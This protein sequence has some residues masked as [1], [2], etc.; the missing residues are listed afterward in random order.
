MSLTASR[1]SSALRR[2]SASDGP[3]FSTA[4]TCCPRPS[5][6][7]VSVPLPQNSSSTRSA[8]P[9]ARSAS[10]CSAGS[11]DRFACANASGRARSRAPFGSGASTITGSP[12]ALP[13]SVTPRTS[14]CWRS[15]SARL[16]KPG[17][18]GPSMRRSMAPFFSPVRRPR[19]TTPGNSPA[20]RATCA[21][22]SSKGSNNRH[23]STGST[24]AAPACANP[25]APPAARCSRAR[26]R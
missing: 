26:R 8:S 2:S 14:G 3:A 21:S 15:S 11:M 18:A 7:N 24:V 17:A 9:T 13:A 20:L 22:S 12:I 5:S 4:L 10:R 23:S 25:Q 16:R 19:S 1:A 6:G